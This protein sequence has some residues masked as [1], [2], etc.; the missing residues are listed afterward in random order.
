M[1]EV[2]SWLSRAL[3]TYLKITK[4]ERTGGASQVIEHLPSNH[5]ALILTSNTDK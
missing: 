2:Q 5:E 1:G 4:V 3:K